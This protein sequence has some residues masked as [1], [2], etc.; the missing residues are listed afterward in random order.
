MDYFV[1]EGSAELS[2][3]IRP[4]GNKNSALPLLAAALLSREP[5]TIE[6]VPD[7]GDVRTKL[8][9]LSGLGV[10]TDYEQSTCRIDAGNL[11]ADPRIPFSRRGYAPP[12]CWRDRCSLASVMP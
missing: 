11:R 3:V 10:A 7:I 1:I 6:N 8:E 4:M 9:L 5:V 12:S 2:G